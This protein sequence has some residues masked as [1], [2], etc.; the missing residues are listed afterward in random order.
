MQIIEASVDKHDLSGQS[1]VQISVSG[2]NL[3]PLGVVFLNGK[4]LPTTWMDEQTLT[5]KV[6]GN[7][8]K[9]GIW[10]VQVKVTDSKDFVIGKTN[11]WP[12]EIGGR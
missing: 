10:D 4:P 2:T 8:L 12:I 1:E 11:S 5:A 3:P 7:L 9:P 6:T